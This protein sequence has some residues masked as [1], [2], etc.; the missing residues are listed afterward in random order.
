[1]S[2]K[3]FIVTTFPNE[4]YY[5]RTLESESEARL[6]WGKL[7]HREDDNADYPK[8]F[9]KGTIIEEVEY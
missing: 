3:W 8:M 1:M 2:E 9:I 6:E 4:G 7:K 5:I